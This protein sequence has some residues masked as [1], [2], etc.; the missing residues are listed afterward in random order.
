MMGSLM[1]TVGEMVVA[2]ERSRGIRGDVGVG[3][4]SVVSQRATPPTGVT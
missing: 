2:R 1:M 4:D 3:G